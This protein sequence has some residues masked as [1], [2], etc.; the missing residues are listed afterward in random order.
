[1]QLRMKIAAA[2]CAVA[3]ITSGCAGSGPRQSDLV[4]EGQ[5]RDA[6]FALVEID[7][8]N[9][10][11]VS[12]WHRPSLVSLF[13]DYRVPMVQRIDVGDSVHVMIW[14]AGAGAVFAPSPERASS[15][16][17]R[18][19]AI[20]EQVVA[21]DGTIQVPYAGRIKV[22]G[23]TPQAV[24]ELIV[25]KLEGKTAEPQ[26]L[27]TLARNVSHA[28]TVTGDVTAGARIPLSSRGDRVLDV[29]AAA[30]GVKAPV[31]ESFISISRD[32]QTLTVPMQAILSS[33][34][35]NVYVRPGDVVTV[36]RAPQSFTA[37][38]STGRQA[39]LHFDAGGLTLEEAVGR[40]GGLNDDRSDPK[41]VFVLRYEPVDLVKGY[42][43]VPSHLLARPV[44]PVAYRL[45]LK[46]ASALF[47]ARRF[48][49][50]NKDILYV[51]HAP[52]TELEKVIRVFGLLTAPAI[53]AVRVTND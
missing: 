8:H 45:N 37:V 10:E 4:A 29:I 44:V 50:R 19:T 21:R 14:E 40:A 30:G 11:V 3:L 46:D 51:S 25:K 32:G 26:A 2:F 13:G 28:A 23:K 9:I 39:L 7:E 35:E 17:A 27:V 20:P 53:T 12:R 33:P 49:M 47:K 36:V 1:M 43:D 6:P 15:A 34:K 52:I 38:G 5:G 22:A 16:G 42:R 24:E 18:Q 41:G 31:H 48:A